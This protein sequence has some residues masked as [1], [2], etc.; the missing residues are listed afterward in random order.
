MAI[1]ALLGLREM[2]RKPAGPA[3]EA[4]PEPVRIVTLY[5]GSEDGSSLRSEA[6]EIKADESELAGLRGVVEALLAGP[7]SGGVALFPSGTNVRGAYIS[8]KI[9]Y[10]DFSREMV[11]GFAGG[12][13]GERLLVASLVQTVCSNFPEVEAVKILV[14]GREIDTIGGHLDVSGTLRAKDWR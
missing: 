13:A 4:R 7:K 9:G 2:L 1:G 12:S 10:V 6:L 5:F 11:D 14:E 3:E 8:D